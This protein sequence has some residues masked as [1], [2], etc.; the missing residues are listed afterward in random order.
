MQMER[1]IMAMDYTVLQESQVRTVRTTRHAQQFLAVELARGQIN[2][3]L[4]SPVFMEF[5][6]LL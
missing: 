3:L 4:E 5:V 6:V 1:L 2:A